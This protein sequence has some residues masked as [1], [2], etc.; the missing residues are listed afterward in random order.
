M[1]TVVFSLFFLIS[2]TMLAQGE[3]SKKNYTK[4]IE[5]TSSVDDAWGLLSNVAMWKEWNS[6]IVDARLSEDFKDKS[7]G[8]LVTANSQVVDFQIVDFV[9]GE[10]YTLRH[11]LSSGTIYL[12]RTLAAT[13][14]G[15]KIMAEVWYK[16]LSSGN[17]KKYMGSDYTMVLERELQSFQQLLQN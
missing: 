6:H 2:I 13:E 9:E 1:R 8:S 5:I 16:G 12:K 7:R 4:E 14:T 10:Q 17:F 15:A 3:H 11:K